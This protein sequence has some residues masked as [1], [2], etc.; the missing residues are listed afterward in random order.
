MNLN[1]DLQRY[2]SSEKTFSEKTFSE[3]SLFSKRN[4]NE[5]NNILFLISVSISQMIKEVENLKAKNNHLNFQRITFL[6]GKI[7]SADS[8]YNFYEFLK[9]YDKNDSY[10]YIKDRFFEDVNL[11]TKLYDIYNKYN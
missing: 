7:H 9:N 6:Q 3:N 11:M 5:L 1:R 2:K 8:F 4:E 10:H